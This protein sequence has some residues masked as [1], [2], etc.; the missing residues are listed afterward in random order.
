MCYIATT[1]FGNGELGQELSSNAFL[2]LL[3]S[4]SQCHEVLPW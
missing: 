2:Y 1:R 3:P 4:L